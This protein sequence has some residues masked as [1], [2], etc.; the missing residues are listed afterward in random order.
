MNLLQ[1]TKDHISLINL[2]DN[3]TNLTPDHIIYIGNQ[4]GTHEM[5]WEEFQVVADFDYYNGFGTANVAEDLIIGFNDGTIMTRWGY[6]GSEGWSDV[7]IP[8]NASPKKIMHLKTSSLDWYIK[9]ING[10][11]G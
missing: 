3:I 8:N 4:S 5:T 10:I 11:N 1:E 7:R 6:D 2:R 9:D